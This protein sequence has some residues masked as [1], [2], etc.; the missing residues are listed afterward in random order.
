M[1]QKKTANV[2][3]TRLISC[4][5]CQVYFYVCRWDHGLLTPATHSVLATCHHI[6][7]LLVLP[8]D[9]LKL[10][11]SVS[12]SMIST[13]KTKNTTD[14]VH[15]HTHIRYMQQWE[16]TCVSFSVCI[17]IPYTGVF[18]LPHLLRHSWRIWY[19]ESSPALLV[20]SYTLESSI[21]IWLKYCGGECTWWFYHSTLLVQAVFRPLL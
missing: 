15:F 10:N 18:T 9:H 20:S 3:S 12:H 14:E 7:T 2:T 1:D 19:G 13:G 4:A 17:L 8:R 6:F 16:K 11:A 21:L 5:H